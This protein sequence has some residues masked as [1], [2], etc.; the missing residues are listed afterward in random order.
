MEP[1]PDDASVNSGRNFR[2]SCFANTSLRRSNELRDISSGFDEQ[3][4]G[5]GSPVGGNP[6]EPERNAGSVPGPERESHPLGLASAAGHAGVIVG[7]HYS[8]LFLS[9][10][11]AGPDKTL[12]RSRRLIG[13]RAPDKSRRAQAGYYESDDP[14][15][16]PRRRRFCAGAFGRR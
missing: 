2:V 16:S 7:Y 3:A 5:A 4:V 15:T 14:S 13:A 6:R 12:P 1:G 11:V 9:S 10:S 8:R